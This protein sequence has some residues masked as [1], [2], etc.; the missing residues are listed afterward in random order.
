MI[1]WAHNLCEELN[2]CRRC[3][4][5]LYQDNQSTIKERGEFDVKYC[6]TT[7]I[8]ADIFTKPLGSTQY[9]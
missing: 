8:L 7:D 3:P 9:A 1:F 6:A 4:T 2:L 5:V